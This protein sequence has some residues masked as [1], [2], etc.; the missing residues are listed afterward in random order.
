MQLL[1]WCNYIYLVCWFKVILYLLLENMNCSFY[2][3]FITGDMNCRFITGAINYIKKKKP[4]C[5]A[6]QTARIG[7]D[8][9][10]AYYGVLKTL[11]YGIFL[12]P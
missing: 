5:S 11:F 4:Y 7:Y 2:K 1:I 6:L 3:I 12:I 8:I 10:R 9:S